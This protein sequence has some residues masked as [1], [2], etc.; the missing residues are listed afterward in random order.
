[1]ESTENKTDFESCKNMIYKLAL[2]AYRTHSSR[3][4]IQFDDVHSEAML[5]YAMCLKNYD[6][7][8]GMK[9]TTYL[10]TNLKGRLNDFYRCTMKPI[11]HYEDMNDYDSRR[12]MEIRYEDTII[13]NERKNDAFLVEAKKELSY[14]GFQVLKYILSEEWISNKV[15]SKP[16][17]KCIM[18]KFGYSSL[19]VES[20][21]GEIRDFWK[22]AYCLVA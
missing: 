2:I 17:I 14:E 7:S 11:E 22:K 9:F 13:E 21:L 20:I 19:I 12:H 10:Y 5:I 1:M 6:S 4:D 3:K 8:K 16:T 15:R 18:T